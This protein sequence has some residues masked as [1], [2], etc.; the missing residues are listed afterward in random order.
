VFVAKKFYTER[1]IEDMAARGI[2]SLE[3][4]DDTVLTELAFEKASRLG[5]SLVQPHQL[6]PAA[7]VRPY[8]SSPKKEPTPCCED[9]SPAN[10]SDEQ[11]RQRIRDAVN[12]KLGTQ[13]DP[14]LL[15]TII[16]RVLNNVGLK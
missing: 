12:V 1:D 7:P 11:L 5:V 15:E 6:P 3:V 14:A 9:N 8:L 13:I 16:T 10:G 4:D 2:L